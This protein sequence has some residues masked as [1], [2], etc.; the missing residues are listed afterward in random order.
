[1]DKG[2]GSFRV[3]FSRRRVFFFSAIFRRTKML[4]LEGFSSCFFFFPFF[5]YFANSQEEFD[6][7]GVFSREAMPYSRRL[8]LLF[9]SA[10]PLLL[11]RSDILCSAMINCGS[12]KRRQSCYLQQ[13]FCCCCCCCRQARE[14]RSRLVFFVFEDWKGQNGGEKRFVV[15][16]RRVF[17][18]NFGGHQPTTLSQAEV[19]IK[20]NP[21]LQASLFFFPIFPFFYFLSVFFPPP[22]SLSF[23]FSTCYNNRSLLEFSNFFQIFPTSIIFLCCLFFFY[24]SSLPRLL[25]LAEYR[26]SRFP[27]FIIRPSWTMVGR[28]V[29]EFVAA[30]GIDA[31]THDDDKAAPLPFLH[32]QNTP[33]FTQSYT[34]SVIDSHAVGQLYIRPVLSYTDPQPISN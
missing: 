20:K 15:V 9:L 5:F 4:K 34:T 33:S 14:K 28:S 21:L 3:A 11:L 32:A 29:V 22:S 13:H 2:R 24:H 10:L 30:E 7:M 18:P 23:E 27:D 8:H 31:C 26:H 25:R 6:G 1:M 17:S 19:K 12:T 16:F